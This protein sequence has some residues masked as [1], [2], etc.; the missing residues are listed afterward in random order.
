M[1]VY[2]VCQNLIFVW[3]CLFLFCVVLGFL[4]GDEYT[5]LN[6]EFEDIEEV[7]PDDEKS[8]YLSKIFRKF[9]TSVTSSSISDRMFCKVRVKG[10]RS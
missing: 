9:L 3:L 1:L 5:L 8:G 6:E 4:V 2:R 7:D 10:I